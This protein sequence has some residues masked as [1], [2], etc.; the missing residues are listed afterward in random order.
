[1]C[2]RGQPKDHDEWYVQDLVG[3]RVFNQV[4]CPLKAVGLMG[5][6]EAGSP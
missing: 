2:R 1:M 3:C 4:G 5:Q 6:G